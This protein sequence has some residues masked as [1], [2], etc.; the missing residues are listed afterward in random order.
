MKRTLAHLES[1]AEPTRKRTRLSPE[2]LPTPPSTYSTQHD[3]PVQSSPLHDSS[4]WRKRLKASLLRPL[5]HPGPPTVQQIAASSQL[6]AWLNAVPFPRARSCPSDQQTILSP[7]ESQV[8]PDSVELQ[9]PQTCEARFDLVGHKRPES[10][11]DRLTLTALHT[12]PQPESQSAES[13][14]PKST[15]SSNKAPGPS[16][17]AYVDTLYGHGIV[18]DLSGRKIP[19]ELV[20]L[21]ERILQ[22]RASPQLDDPAVNA[23][24]DIAED[25]AYNSEGPTNKI[26]RTSMFPLDYGGL[27]EGGNTQWNTVALPNNPKCDNKLSAPK[28]D[29][30]LAYARGPKS[31]W[32]VEQ[33]NVV[34]HPKARPYTQPA[35]RNTFPS[36]SVE[37]KAESAGGVLT[38]AEAQAAGSGSHSVN[39]IRWLLEQAKAAGLTGVDLVQDTVS[40]SVV[41]SHRQAVAYL[42]WL[43]PK[44]KQFYISYL[45]SYPTFEAHSIRGCN[46]AIKNIIDNAEGPRQIQIGKALV[47]LRPFINSWNTQLTVPNEPLNT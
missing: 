19:Q 15:S 39:S 33:N 38:T 34:N 13:L 22:K 6:S 27:V 16:D 36:L 47:I 41:A 30:Y 10:G 44:E 20:S 12:M 40:F 3:Y 9:R 24:M 1:S 18:M 11:S 45:R 21:K 42:H 5:D 14:I 37:L 23:V 43:D 17:A 8:R 26:L 31:P 7:L 35:K 46:N 25:L 28:P 32:T 29:A 4:D 2:Q